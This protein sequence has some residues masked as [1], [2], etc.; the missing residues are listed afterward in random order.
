MPFI[1]AIIAAVG[2]VAAAGVGAAVTGAMAKRAAAPAPA[3]AKEAPKE[4]PKEAIDGMVQKVGDA[5]L[6]KLARMP[7]TPTAAGA[8]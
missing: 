6:A 8:A 3:P 5:I 4:V 2:G 1:P 7:S